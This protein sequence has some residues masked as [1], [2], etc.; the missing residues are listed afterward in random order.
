MTDGPYAPL[1][2]SRQ[3]NDFGRALVRP[4]FE[5]EAAPCL[6]RAVLGD[7]RRE[8]VGELSSF[9]REALATKEPELFPDTGEGALEAARSLFLHAD[10]AIGTGS[11]PT[12]A[13]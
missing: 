13:A 6:R 11:L 7:A 1:S 2:L 12:R 3:W 5:E 8:Q 4:A 9:L 10:G